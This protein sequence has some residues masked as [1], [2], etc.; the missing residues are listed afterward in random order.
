MRRSAWALASVLLLAAPVRAATVLDC[1]RPPT[2][3]IDAQFLDPPGPQILPGGPTGNFLRLADTVSVHR[4]SITFDLSDPGPHTVIVADFDFRMR[5]QRLDSRADGFGFTLLS[6]ARYGTTGFLSGGSE[7]PNRRESL[8]IGF[9]IHQGT[10]EVS[11]N[12]VSVHWDSTEVT[13]V[14][15]SPALDLANGFFNHARIIVR[16]DQVTPNVSV[17]ITP[18]GGAPVTVIDRLAVP[19]LVPYES[20]VHFM[21]RSGGERALHDLDNV[22]VAFADAPFTIVSFALRAVTA[23]E[24][25]GTGAVLTLERIGNDLG[26][27]GAHVTVSTIDRTALAGADYVA[28][29]TMAVFAPGQA[30]ATVT[31]PLTDDAGFENDETFVARLSAPGAAVIGG[32]DE[33]TVTI[34]DDERGRASGHWSDPVCLPVVPIHAA[35]LPQGDVLFW[36]GEDAS[37]TR[38][39]GDQLFRWHPES[40]H[41]HHAAMPGFDIFCGGQAIAADGRVFVAGGHDGEDIGLPQAALYDPVTDTWERLPDMNAGRWYPTCTLLPSGDLLVVA[42]STSAALMNTLPQV[43]DVRAH[44]WRDLTGARLDE[45]ELG[46]YYPWMQ[47]VGEDR[48]FCAGR[49]PTCYALDPRG[50]GGWTKV[51]DSAGDTRGYGSAVMYEQGRILITG[52][53]R[54]DRAVPP[55]ILPEASA[56]VIDLN[57]ASPAWRFTAPMALRRRYLNLT[58]LPDGG[59]LATGGTG[60]AGIN[61]PIPAALTAERWDPATETWA[62]L[63]AMTIPRL[64]HSV[65][66]L[67]PDGR[68]MSGGGG[69]PSPPGHLHHKDAEIFSPPYLFRGARPALTGAPASVRYGETMLLQTPDGAR[70]E[71]VRLMGLAAVT[72]AYDASQRTVPLVPQPAAGGVWVTVPVDSA[73]C[74]PGPYLAFLVTAD[75]VPS[76][77]RVVRVSGPPRI[78]AGPP[79]GTSLAVHGSLPQPSVGPLRIWFTLATHEPATLALYDITGRAIGESEEVGHL[80]VGSHVVT[81]NVREVRSGVYLARITQGG[82]TVSKRIVVIR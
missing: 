56:E 34:V 58:L 36:P 70:V 68:V 35:L 79:R 16:A 71:T 3:F 45:P 80:G 74:P 19:G 5:P 39:G 66:L 54:P 6:T 33:A 20:R 50:A 51:G 28:T 78:D 41:I 22:H 42:G 30:T 60:G 69:Q 7:E 10:G 32:P 13:E 76:V 18:C 65:A 11:A 31:V 23:I 17:I 12:H 52:G 15:V 37:N 59:V 73:L 47:V 67:L 21:A 75:G 61:N 46:R 44:A 29:S 26:V 24:N 48:V 77:A 1:D 62:T 27:T 81:P 49:E 25:G 63:A 82:R 8:G 14:D 43:W 53:V 57:D 72:H 55:T 40:G 38:M 64:Y 4:N 2:P 9:D